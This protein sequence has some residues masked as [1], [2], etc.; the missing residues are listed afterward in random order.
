MK[1]NTQ[2]DKHINILS[3]YVPIVER[4]HGKHHPEFH[5]VRS[6]FDKLVIALKKEDETAIHQIFVDLRTITN[7]YTIPKDVCESYA[8]VYELLQELDTVITCN[9]K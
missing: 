8:T 2:I 9:E 6:S 4:V 1:E 5:D 7:H 3:Q